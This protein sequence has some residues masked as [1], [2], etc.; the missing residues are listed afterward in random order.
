MSIQLKLRRGTTAQHSTFTGASGEVTVDTDKKTLVVHDGVTAGGSAL[1]TKTGAE[2]LTNKTLTTPV[3]NGFTGDMSVVNLGSGQFYKDTSGN[4]GIGTGSP[5]SLANFKFLDV[6]SGSTNQG[7]VQANNGTVKTAI[8]ANGTEGYVATRTSHNLNFQT[9]GTTRATIDSSGNVGIGT[10][11]PQSTFQVGS[12]NA[13]T[14]ESTNKGLVMIQSAPSTIDTAGGLE[15]KTSSSGSGYGWKIGGLNTTGDPF[16]IGNRANSASFTERMR[17]DS[18]GQFYTKDG[19]GNVKAAY[20]C[21]AWVNFN[22]TTIRGSGNVTSI[23]RNGNCDYTVN[24]ATAISDTNYATVATA[25]SATGQ[26]GCVSLAFGGLGGT[27]GSLYSASQVELF[28]QNTNGTRSTDVTM[29]NVAI[30][31]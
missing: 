19:A 13:G 7:V 6:G 27:V 9:G 20:D 5:D 15:F 31:R 4:V 8:Y 21:R 30:F 24:M 25:N 17:I 12:I 23:T 29:V 26:A 10:S 2:T 28:V 22:S 11:S 1:V 18:S 14:S 3:I 16:V